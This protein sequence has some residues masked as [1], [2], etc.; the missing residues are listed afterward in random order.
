MRVT[1]SDLKA[2]FTSI[3]LLPESVGDVVVTCCNGD[4]LEFSRC[5]GEW[6]LLKTGTY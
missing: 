3:A 4:Y 2:V 6:Q 1:T 5:D